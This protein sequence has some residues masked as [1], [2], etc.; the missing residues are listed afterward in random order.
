MN[1]PDAVVG[2]VDRDVVT[3]FTFPQ[4]ALLVVTFRYIC[5]D[6]QEPH[7]TTFAVAFHHFAVAVNPAPVAALAADPMNGI[8]AI[9]AFQGALD[10]GAQL[11][12]LLLRH[13]PYE[14][15]RSRDRC[16]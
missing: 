2:A 15:F 7:C 4:C 1:I 5:I 8:I 11:A 13:E 14:V 12:S 3:L 16:L 9:A 10:P 6:S